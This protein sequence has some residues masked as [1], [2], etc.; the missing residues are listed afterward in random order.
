MV[1]NAEKLL[2]QLESENSHADN[3]TFKIPDDPRITGV[4]RW[5]RRSSLDELPQFLH[6]LTGEMSLVGP[7]PPV[8]AEVARY[9]QRDMRRLEVKPGLTCIWQVSGRSRLPFPEQL[10]MDID[11]IKR[12]SLWLDLVLLV[13]TIP[14]VVSADG[15]Y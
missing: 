2:S 11:Y 1:Q 6:V 8:P 5:L 9:N 12:R 15:A 4:G 14:A 3:R 7:R 10:E 13:R